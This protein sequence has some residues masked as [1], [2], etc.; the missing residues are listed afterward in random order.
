VVAAIDARFQTGLQKELW[1]QT[2][3]KSAS[4]S[5]SVSQAEEL[6]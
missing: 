2:H 1:G 3:P 6:S 4:D 5:T